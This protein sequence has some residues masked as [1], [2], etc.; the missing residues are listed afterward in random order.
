MR[1][2]YSA[3]HE[4]KIDYL[5]A[6]LHPS[7]RQVTDRETLGRVVATTTWSGLRILAVDGG[8]EGDE[9]GQVEFVAYYCESG[10]SKGQDGSTKQLHERSRFIKEDGRWF[11]LSGD[12]ES[13]RPVPKLGRN[14]LCW[15]GSGKKSKK[16]HNR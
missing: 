5:I 2:R 13:L 6:T 16:C 15:C 11:Y 1:S 7:K 9:T 10:A 3:F 4:G 8:T 12:Q 14:D